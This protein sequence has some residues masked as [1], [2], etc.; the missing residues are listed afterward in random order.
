MQRFAVMSSWANNVADPTDYADINS[1]AT[2][3]ATVLIAQLAAPTANSSGT[4]SVWDRD[5]MNQPLVL[6]LNINY[7]PPQS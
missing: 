2:A 1:A 5:W 7:N 4:V 3:A 6:S